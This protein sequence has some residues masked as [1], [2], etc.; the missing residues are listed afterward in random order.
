MWSMS[1]SLPS[2]ASSGEQLVAQV[3]RDLALALEG[4]HDG[5]AA[6]AHRSGGAAAAAGLVADAAAEVEAD[7]DAEAGEEARVCAVGARDELL[8]VT[9]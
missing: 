7:A 8:F 6:A 1:S 4:V 5:L 3:A 9:A 2:A